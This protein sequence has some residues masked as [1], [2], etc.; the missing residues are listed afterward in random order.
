M[1]AD[2]SLR[3]FHLFLSLAVGACWTWAI[4][5]L[6]NCKDPARKFITLLEVAQGNFVL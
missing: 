6:R 5:R 1:A 4:R 3:Y 2:T